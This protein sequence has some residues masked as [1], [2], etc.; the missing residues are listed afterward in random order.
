MQF[1][2]EKQGELKP[3]HAFATLQGLGVSGEVEGLELLLGNQ[4]LM[5]QQGV[6]IQPA[7]AIFQQQTER[8]ATV[9]FLRSIAN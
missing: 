6:D 3:L 5:I 8:G 9:V 1:N 7:M 2:Q 4:T